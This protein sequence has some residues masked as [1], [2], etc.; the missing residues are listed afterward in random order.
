MGTW[1]LMTFDIFKR[2]VELYG[3]TAVECSYHHWQIKGG[4]DA[5]I[6]NVW[7]NGKTGFK[8]QVAGKLKTAGRAKSKRGNVKDAIDAAGIP[9]HP[10][11]DTSAPWQDEPQRVGLIRWLWRLIW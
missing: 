1:E 9:G 7:A 3:L 8:Y 5:P 10:A 2:Q 4:S 11:A 6:V